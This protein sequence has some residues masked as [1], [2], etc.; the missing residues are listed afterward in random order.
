M[1]DDIGGVAADLGYLPLALAQAA[2][3][4]IDREI[5]CSTYRVRLADRRRSL[6]HFL[7]EP[8]SL[9]DEHRATVAAT[10]SLS[11]EHADTLRPAGLARP[12]LRL[13]SLLDPNG[14]PAPVLTAAP[15]LDWLSAAA[16]ARVT[17]DDVYDA[18]RNLHLLNLATHDPG[19]PA[20]SLR[21]HALIQRATRDQT[22]TG[23]RDNATLSAADA[24]Q[25]VWPP[26]E[27]D[28]DLGQALRANTEHL[29]H[30]NPALD[31]RAR[32]AHRTVHGGHPPRRHRAGHRSRRLL[33][34]P[35][36]H[37]TPAPRPRPPRHPDRPQQPRPQTGTGR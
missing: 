21:V 6:E 30:T 27:T 33:P 36:P 2:A 18:V 29:H 4:M 17:A 23:A 1:A 25:A 34:A 7:P 14:I 10:W 35:A 32:R 37:R 5:T 9:P 12:V 24:L 16:G 22:P 19:N 20:R 31:T 26:V 28:P 8:E 13:A 11:I 15:V 3:Y